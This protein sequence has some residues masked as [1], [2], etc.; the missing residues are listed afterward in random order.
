MSHSKSL[1]DADTLAEEC[2]SCPWDTSKLIRANKIQQVTFITVSEYK[3]IK[4]V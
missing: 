3:L 2:E 1:S 4:S